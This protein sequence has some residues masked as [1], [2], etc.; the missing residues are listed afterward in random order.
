M[1][2]KQENRQLYTQG[3]KLFNTDKKYVGQ[4]SGEWKVEGATSE[5]NLKC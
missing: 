5:F 3:E 4:K 2:A 1:E